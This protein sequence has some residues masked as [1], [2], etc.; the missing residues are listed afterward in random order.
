[1]IQSLGKVHVGKRSPCLDGV[2]DISTGNHTLRVCCSQS[3][4][5]DTQKK[6]EY[7]STIIALRTFYT[8]VF[9]KAVCR[10][11]GPAL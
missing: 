11:I 9:S 7:F 1:M 5:Q 4:F 8:S 10:E 6:C 3:E 2:H